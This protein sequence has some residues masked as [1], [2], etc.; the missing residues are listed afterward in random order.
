MFAILTALHR[1]TQS[2]RDRNLIANPE[3]YLRVISIDPSTRKSYSSSAIA[4]RT[5]PHHVS[6][7]HASHTSRN[8]LAP[9]PAYVLSEASEAS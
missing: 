1:L 3:P 4:C 2:L 6:E 5:F 7:R 9:L 8:P